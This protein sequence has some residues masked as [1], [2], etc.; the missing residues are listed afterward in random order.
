MKKIKVELSA[1]ELSLLTDALYKRWGVEVLEDNPESLAS[2]LYNKLFDAD[3]KLLGT[4]Y[5]VGVWYK[6]NPSK[7]PDTIKYSEYTLA[8]K[9]EAE[10]KMKA[11]DLCGHE[12]GQTAWEIDIQ[13]RIER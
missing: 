5:V 8:A 1:K 9:S 7:N 2:K 10:A 12:H 13:E 4:L 6:P 3:A 11:G